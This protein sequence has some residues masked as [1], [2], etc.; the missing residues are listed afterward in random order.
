MLG[1]GLLNQ[2]ARQAEPQACPIGKQQD[3]ESWEDDHE[4]PTGYGQETARSE[5]DKNG[6]RRQGY[7]QE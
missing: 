7:A 3:R 6:D 5:P 4:P 1:V 2:T